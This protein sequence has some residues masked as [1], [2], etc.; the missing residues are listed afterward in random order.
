MSWLTLSFTTIG[1]SEVQAY[2]QSRALRNGTG[3]VEGSSS[4]IYTVQSDDKGHTSISPTVSAGLNTTE[5]SID[6]DTNHS[7]FTETPDASVFL[8]LDPGTLFVRINGTVGP[9]H[10]SSN[11][12]IQPQPPYGIKD[13][14]GMDKTTLTSNNRQKL[15]S[16][17]PNHEATLYFATLDTTVTYNLTLT[18]SGVHNNHSRWNVSRLS[19]HSFEL[20]LNY[21]D[22]TVSDYNLLTTD[23]QILSARKARV[24][25]GPIAGG[26]LSIRQVRVVA[27]LGGHH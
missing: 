26:V 1:I 3:R 18:N 23:C 5:W 10:G 13:T 15:T 11:L 20:W 2:S 19:I 17:T 24:E 22:P 12:A 7:I 6:P 25:P 14:R 4:V 27:H 9:G 16:D 21:S 8:R